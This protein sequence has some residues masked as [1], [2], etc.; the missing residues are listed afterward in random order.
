MVLTDAEPQ[1]A[2][3]SRPASAIRPPRGLGCAA[4]CYAV[5]LQ[6]SF[7]DVQEHAPGVD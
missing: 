4:R 5:T 1:S 2:R 3:S 6:R 7:S